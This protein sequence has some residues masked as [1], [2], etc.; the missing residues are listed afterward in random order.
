MVTELNCSSCVQHGGRALR[1]EHLSHK[2]VGV[3]VKRKSS[4]IGGLSRNQVYTP[5][6]SPVPPPSDSNDSSHRLKP[7]FPR[8][9]PDARS[10][11]I[12]A[13]RLRTIKL[14]RANVFP[15]D[16]NKLPRGGVCECLYLVVLEAGNPPERRTPSRL[17]R[18]KTSGNEEMI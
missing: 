9:N 13:A 3:S 12:C 16:K 8:L 18:D 1:V 10:S 14:S 6:S 4:G 11:F 7:S 17:R 5:P 2:D 15:S